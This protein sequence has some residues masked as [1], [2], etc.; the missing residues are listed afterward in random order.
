MPYTKHDVG[1]IVTRGAV[2][3]AKSAIHVTDDDETTFCGI[4]IP[5]TGQPLA[6]DVRVSCIECYAV[7]VTLDRYCR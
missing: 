6:G 3:W 2:M 4:A 5:P 1:M 7:A